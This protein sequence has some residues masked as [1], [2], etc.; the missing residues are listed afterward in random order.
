[1]ESAPS[2]LLLGPIVPGAYPAAPDTPD[3]SAY[4]ASLLASSSALVDS[5]ST[6]PTSPHWSK[7]KLFNEKHA[8]P[9]HTFS[10]IS[11]DRPPP[12]AGDTGGWKWHARVS[13]HDDVDWDSFRDGLMVDHSVHEQ[14]YIDSAIKAERLSVIKEGE[15]ELWR[16]LYHQPFPASNRSF[17]FLLYT[18]EQSPVPSVR[19]PERLLRSFVVVSIPVALPEAPPEKGFVRARY[20]SVEQ[21]KERDEGGVVWTMAVSSDA[22]GLV[23]RWISERVMPAKISEDV[24]SFIDWIKKRTPGGNQTHAGAPPTPTTAPAAPQGEP[25]PQVVITPP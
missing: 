4:V 12:G 7:G 9:T 14:E 10:T 6:D 19:N 3:Y 18:A 20:V 1:M 13:V 25:H 15:M 8:L 2:P 5:L 17:T 23:P 24:P 16:M 21:V 11:P 22:G